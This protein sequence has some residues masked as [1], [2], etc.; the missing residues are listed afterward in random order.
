MSERKTIND[1]QFYVDRANEALRELG[2]TDRYITVYQAYGKKRL[3]WGHTDDT[4]ISDLGF[5]GTIRET[6]DQA[7]V[8][9]RTLEELVFTKQAT[10]EY[11][12]SAKFDSR[13]SFYGKA[14]VVET[15]REKKLYSYNTP[16]CVIRHGQAFRADGQPQSPTTARHMSEFLC[17][18]IGM[19]DGHQY[20]K[21]DLLALPTAT[22]K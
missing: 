2:I 4:G 18:T 11:E 7:Y 20:G 13:K 16:V 5:S 9:A 21:R 15:T 1:V 12:L 3:M 14:R 17:Q 6:Y 19:V 8:I 22:I 10:R